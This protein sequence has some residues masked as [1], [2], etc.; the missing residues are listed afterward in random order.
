MPLRYDIGS[1][2]VPPLAGLVS[3]EMSEAEL[4]E[5]CGTLA[6]W[7]AMVQLRSPR[8]SADDDVDPYLSRYSVPG[9]K[10]QSTQ[11]VSLK[12]HGL[13]SAKWTMQLFVNML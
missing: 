5:S 11:L 7:I 1:I 10:S 4:Q 8:V 13:V 12:W 3:N 9:D 2:K 6:E